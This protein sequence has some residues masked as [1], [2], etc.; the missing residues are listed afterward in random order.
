MRFARLEYWIGF[1]YL[2]S[3]DPDP[4]VEPTSLMSPAVTS[5]F[6]STSATWE[7]LALAY[8]SQLL[9]SPPKSAF[10]DIAGCHL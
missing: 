2:P 9:A 7:A 6:F 4:G 8:K 10:S 5:G 1:P 3:G